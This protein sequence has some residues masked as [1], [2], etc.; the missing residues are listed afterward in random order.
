MKKFLKLAFYV[1]LGV[2]AVTVVY[3]VYDYQYTENEA[4]AAEHQL[5]EALS[6]DPDTMPTMVLPTTGKPTEIPAADQLGASPAVMAIVDKRGG[7]KR[8]HLRDG[9]LRACEDQPDW[10][11][12]PK[13]VDRGQF[14]RGTSLD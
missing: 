2:A 10:R 4:R 8:I 5:D 12:L 13:E 7:C 1:F 11:S 6:S 9:N 3:N 14:F